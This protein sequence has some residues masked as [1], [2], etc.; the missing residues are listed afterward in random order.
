MEN[1]GQVETRQLHTGVGQYVTQD[2]SRQDVP[3]RRA[4]VAGTWY[5][6]DPDTLA[7]EVDA[8]LDEVQVVSDADISALV[9][10][11]AGLVYSGSVGAYAYRPLRGR[12]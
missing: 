5:P 7:R 1:S 10:P 4:A 12:S 3:V 11:H 6:A 9:V 2:S 8:Y